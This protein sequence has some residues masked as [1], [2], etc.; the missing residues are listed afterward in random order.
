MAKLDTP[1]VRDLYDGFIADYQ[2]RTGQ[3]TPLLQAAFV[4]ILAWAEAGMVI[5]AFRFG[6]WV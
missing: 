4:R 5:L 6:R 2:E 1:S 3:K